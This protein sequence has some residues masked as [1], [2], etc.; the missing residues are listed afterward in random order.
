MSALLRRVSNQGALAPLAG[1]VIAA[2]TYS[3]LGPP[4]GWSALAWLV[5]RA[6]LVPL[7]RWSIHRA[8][9][10]GVAFAVLIGVGITGWASDITSYVRWGDPWVIA[11]AAVRTVVQRT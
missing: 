2:A 9:V 5:P 3:L 4:H 11:Q 7:A 10:W 8:F 6:L 1:V